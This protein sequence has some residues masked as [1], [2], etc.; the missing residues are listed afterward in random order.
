MIEG[1][2]DG[3]DADFS[4]LAVRHPRSKDLQTR[5]AINPKKN[6]LTQSYQS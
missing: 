2:V 6:G 3:E 5:F 4:R 1:V